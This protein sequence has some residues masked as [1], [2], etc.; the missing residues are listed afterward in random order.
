M[1]IRLRKRHTF[2]ILMILVV[3][4]ALFGLGGQFL[5][6]RLLPQPTP[7]A[8]P[9]I[10]P[11]F[12][13]FYNTLGGFD[14]LGAALTGLVEREGRTCQYTD[15]ALMCF[16]RSGSQTAGNYTL[17]PLGRQ[18][19]GSEEKPLAVSQSGSR[20][21]GGGFVLYEEFAPLYNR[22]F[23]ALFVGRPL[24][25]VRVNHDLG[26]YEQFFENVGFYRRFDD[27]PEQVHLLPY[28]AYLCGPG[29][30]QKLDEFWITQQSAL[31]A[32]P[33]EL[34]VQRLGLSDLGAPLA[35]PKR[36]DDGYIE[37]VYDNALLYAPENDLSQVR[38]RPLVRML[39]FVPVEEPGPEKPH[40]QLAFYEVRDG[41][42][43]NVPL[44]FDRF[45]AFHGGRDLAGDPLTELFVL[46]PERLYR[47][48]F[49]NY[50]LDYD[51]L[52]PAQTRVRMVALGL[53]Y[54][55]RTDPAQ[56]LRRAF[57]AETVQLSVAEAHPQLSKDQTQEISLHVYHR[58]DG[59]PMYL[60]EGMLTLTY[61]DRPS[62]TY[63]FSPTDNAGRS[64]VQFKVP[65]DLANMSI[66]EY[67]VCLNL[68]ADPQICATESFF[69]RNR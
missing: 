37:Q 60:V 47:Q 3:F 63:Y 45:V 46:E 6:P 55:R 11:L 10:D 25:Q 28:G 18:V 16:E 13:E 41:L 67:R 34:S 33:F 31:I 30:S 22:L 17:A 19:I 39:D 8:G 64:A 2:G 44:F 24:T 12:K 66:V 21:L 14:V 32:Q 52:A 56:M 38:L 49:E 23:G 7:T 9:A 5:M 15:A 62:E 4:L 54:V 26:R 43:F 65:A 53:E 40:E 50:C 1:K 36:T 48:C 68:P 58:Q 69:Y 35:Q 42:G 29:C 57:S 51:A 20:D 59:A 27:A 61:P